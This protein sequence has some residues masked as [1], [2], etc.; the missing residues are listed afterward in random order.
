MCR[1][2]LLIFTRYPEAGI[3]K[4]RLIPQL[5]A[6]GAARLQ[7]KLA[8]GIIFQAKVL[9]EKFQIRTTVHY[10]GGDREKMASWLGPLEYQAQVAGDLGLRMQAAFAHAFAAGVEKAVLIDSDI[11]DINAALLADAFVALESAEVVIGRSQ[12]GGYYLI[13]L[14]AEAAERLFPL[15]FE[16]VP[17]STPEVFAITCGRLAEAACNPAILP[18][19]RDIDTPDDL[20]FARE[21]GLL[22]P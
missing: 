22:R 15:V 4:T 6:E 1:H 17:W 2:H 8:E 21:K 18:T 14:R 9:A 5:G 19:L 10:L 20:D 7:K 3:T 13:G 12:D 16:Q 11:P